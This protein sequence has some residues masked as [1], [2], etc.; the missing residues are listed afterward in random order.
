MRISFMA[1]VVGLALGVV[2]CSKRDTLVPAPASN[3]TGGE[4]AVV[5]TRA[6]APA[7]KA[8]PSQDDVSSLDLDR[9]SHVFHHGDRAYVVLAQVTQDSWGRGAPSLVSTESPVTVRRDVDVAALPAALA[10]RA[11][12]SVRL[13]GPSGVVCQGVIGPMSLV[14]RFEP[15]FGTRQDWE[16]KNHDIGE[17]DAPLP[18]AHVATE[19]WDESV[20]GRVLAAEVISTTGDCKRALFARAA[21]LPAP[22][23]IAQQPAP[24]GL[25]GKAVDA[26]RRLP[27]YATIEQNYRQSSSGGPGRW[28]VENGST[29]V[30][31]FG[32]KNASYVWVS[33][34]GGEVCSDFN[35]HLVALWKVE[36]E[37]TARPTFTLLH[38]GTEDLLPVGVT[39]IDGDGSVELIGHERLL[40]RGSEGHAIDSLAVPSFVCPC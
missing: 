8:P 14:G 16:G 17:P 10:R 31:F 37:G 27:S 7:P 39:D 15:H 32:G 13:I 21:S 36:G 3:T 4:G 2:G 23:I 19:A 18:V 33:A 29:D 24:H 5:V 20:A 11:G 1:V 38:E 40:R 34:Q 26:L 35:A 6:P 28:E 12:R 22:A 9:F 30:T 25:A